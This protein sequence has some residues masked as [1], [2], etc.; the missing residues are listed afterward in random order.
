MCTHIHQTYYFKFCLGK[1]CLESK[2]KFVKY[3]LPRTL[4]ATDLAGNTVKSKIT[5]FID[6]KFKDKKAK[7]NE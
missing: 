7:K 3:Y 1:I 2:I 5:S 6:I 4:L